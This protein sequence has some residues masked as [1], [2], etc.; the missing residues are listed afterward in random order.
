MLAQ[1]NNPTSALRTTTGVQSGVLLTTP[2]PASS[3]DG[4]SAGIIAAIVV[5]SVLGCIIIIACVYECCFRKEGDPS[6][7]EHV[8]NG[9]G[10]LGSWL[11]CCCSCGEQNAY[12]SPTGFARSEIT[13]A[14]QRRFGS[15]ELASQEAQKYNPPN[16]PSGW[17]HIQSLS[18][19]M[20]AALVSEHY[21][22]FVKVLQP[23]NDI[24][25]EADFL[26][27]LEA[28]TLPTDSH[29]DPILE[30]M[31]NSFRRAGGVNG[32]VDATKLVVAL[33]QDPGSLYLRHHGH[34]HNWG[35]PVLQELQA[36]DH[37]VIT[38]G[39]F[40]QKCSVAI[41]NSRLVTSQASPPMSAPAPANALPVCV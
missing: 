21:A 37:R 2:A 32:F 34:E 28:S 8:T 15:I 6:V 36:M 27:T 41:Q 12:N 26:R 14:L 38:W 18:V 29:S 7:W 20:E 5:G 19:I 4:L 17:I 31:K 24:F 35:A 23:T 39:E 22:D 16:A 30:S 13:A 1:S 25:S 33:Q 10:W 11:C 9:W 40:E 3:D